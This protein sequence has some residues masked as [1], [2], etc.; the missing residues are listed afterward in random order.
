MKDARYSEIKKENDLLVSHLT[1]NYKRIADI[2]IKKARGY[3]VKNV[4]TELKIQD[5]LKELEEK[6]F[7]KVPYNTFIS[8]ETK[9]INGQIE[10]LSKQVKDPDRIKTIIGVSLIAIFIIG[11][12]VINFWMRQKSSIPQVQN[13]QY[14]LVSS[15]KLKLTWNESDFAVNGYIIW[16]EDLNGEIVQ[17][18]YNVKE[19]NYVF[20]IEEDKAYKFF[21]QVK[22]SDYYKSSTPVEIIYNPNN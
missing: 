1:G 15:S 18:K 5:A 13:V 3:A 22:D 8:D 9:F 17:G 16:S 19:C 21:V 2:Y 10:K 6:N 7:R 11:W 14:E 20:K 4:D 12:G